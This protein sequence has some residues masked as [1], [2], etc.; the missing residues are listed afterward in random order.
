MTN[1]RKYAFASLVVLAAALGGATGL[2]MAQGSQSMYGT[3][4]SAPSATSTVEGAAPPGEP[5]AI[6]PAP[7]YESVPAYVAPPNSP[8]YTP[9]TGDAE[10][11]SKLDPVGPQSNRFNDATGQ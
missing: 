9:E 8:R 2:A 4:P 1:S 5:A 6:E 11:G 7:V 3:S 10:Y